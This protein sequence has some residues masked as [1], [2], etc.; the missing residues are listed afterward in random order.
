MSTMRIA[1]M[2]AV[3]VLLSGCEPRQMTAWAEPNYAVVKT[4]SQQTVT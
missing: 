2:V 3:V 4:Y 1:F